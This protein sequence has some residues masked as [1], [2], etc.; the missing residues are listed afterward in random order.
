FEANPSGS[1]DDARRWTDGTA[2]GAAASQTGLNI[3]LNTVTNTYAFFFDDGGPSGS[4]WNWGCFCNKPNDDNDFND[5]VVTYT[6]AA[7]PEPATMALFGAGLL[8][9]G[10]ARRMRRQA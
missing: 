10:A 9:L 7:I 2:T 8:G 3:F 6:P 1:S 5:L 4:T